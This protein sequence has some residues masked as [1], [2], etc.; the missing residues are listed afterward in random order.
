MIMVAGSGWHC[1]IPGIAEDH[2]LLA[3]VVGRFLGRLRWLRKIAVTYGRPA[4][5]FVKIEMDLWP[6]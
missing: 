1:D 3:V 2:V 6:A 5:R 4:T